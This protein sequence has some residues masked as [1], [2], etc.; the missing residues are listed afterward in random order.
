MK[1]GDHYLCAEDRIEYE[2]LEVE[3]LTAKVRIIKD[4]SWGLPSMK[5]DT[6]IGRKATPQQVIDAMKA[7]LSNDGGQPKLISWL[8]GLK[9]LVVYTGDRQ[10][11]LIVEFTNESLVEFSTGWVA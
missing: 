7:V 9:A 10:Q 4:V 1:P 11:T 8:T 3:E 5:N 6:Y 2:I